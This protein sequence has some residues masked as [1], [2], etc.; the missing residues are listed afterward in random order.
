MLQAQVG[1]VTR[2][3]TWLRGRC[4]NSRNNRICNDCE[5]NEYLPERE[6]REPETVE[7]GIGAGGEWIW[8]LRTERG[9]PPVGCAGRLRRYPE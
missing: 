2:S 3:L 1:S 7:T 4:Y 6:V 5:Q 8:E 9:W